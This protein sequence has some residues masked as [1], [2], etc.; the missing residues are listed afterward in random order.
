MLVNISRPH[1][2]LPGTDGKIH[3]LA[4]YMEKIVVVH[5]WSAECPWSER[6]D[7]HFAEYNHTFSNNVVVLPVA[8]NSNE[9][10]E[11]IQ[12][13]MQAHRL[14]LV[15]LDHNNHLADA[16]DAQITP[17]AFVFDQTGLLRYKGA[18]DDVTFRKR[19]PEHFYVKEVI[20]A[21]LGAEAPTLQ[22]TS[23]YGCTIV[24]AT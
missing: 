7:L 10:L 20:S 1:F 19:T 12:Q 2:S 6:A 11:Q 24:R 18:V 3:Q 8:S 21:L 9:T 22:E 16:W 4:D 14:G 15:L 23:P 17:H 13:T 5:F